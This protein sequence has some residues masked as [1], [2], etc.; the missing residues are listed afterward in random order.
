MTPRRF[1]PLGLVALLLATT[2]A[3]AQPVPGVG[4][5]PTR[6]GRGGVAQP[7][8]PPVDQGTADRKALEAASLKADDPKGLLDYLRQRTLSDADLS[9][10]Q[11]VIRRLGSDDFEERLRAS[12][13][14]ERFGP[15]AVGPLRAASQSDT[16][17]EIA[18]RAG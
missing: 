7:P 6:R 1:P 17:Y 9:Q 3:L 15:A 11:A 8:E 4:D 13:E 14:V 10:I 16:D 12:A 2:A 5:F 18:F